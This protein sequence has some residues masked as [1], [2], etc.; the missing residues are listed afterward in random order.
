LAFGGELWSVP[1]DAQGEPILTGELLKRLSAAGYPTTDRQPERWRNEELLPR[2]RP[3]A[4]R[5]APMRHLPDA[6][7]QAIAIHPCLAV[8]NRFDFAGS[9][10]WAAG[11]DVGEQH[12]VKRME[13]ADRTSQRIRPLANWLMK[14]AE[15]LYSDRTLGDVVGTSNA[16]LTG[17]V[18]KMSRR[19]DVDE[20]ARLF[21]VVTEVASGDFDE[22]NPYTTDE[23][24]S[25]SDIFNRAFGFEQASKD[26]VFGSRLRP[27]TTLGETL[28]DISEVLRHSSLHDFLPEEIQSARDDVRNT[29]KIATCFHDAMAWFYGP[30]A[31]GFRLAAFF[32][33]RLPTQSIYDLTLSFARF[34]KV[35]A[36]IY[37]SSEIRLLARQAESTWLISTYSVHFIARDRTWLI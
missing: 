25:T 34:R 5:G 31:F 37:T 19:L 1:V 6:V 18:A 35:G 13:G 22:Y 32:A 3:N 15:R 11:F 28:K 14:K 12:Y 16:R 29:L 17:I 30:N 27:G 33:Q 2:S 20:E 7:A 36:K 8:K 24:I 10:L 4:F 26:H 21:N 9:L 23:E